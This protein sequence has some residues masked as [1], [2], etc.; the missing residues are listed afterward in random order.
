MRLSRRISADEFSSF[1]AMMLAGIIFLVSGLAF[2]ILIA[3][4]L[5]TFFGLFLLPWSIWIFGIWSWT[6]LCLAG[7]HVVRSI[8]LVNAPEWRGLGLIGVRS[9]LAIVTC[10]V[11][12]MP[13]FGV[14][15]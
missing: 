5:I 6:A 4:A 14:G 12:W 9:A 3:A 13:V 11:L 15:L 7:Y 8:E 1:A 2:L 10:P